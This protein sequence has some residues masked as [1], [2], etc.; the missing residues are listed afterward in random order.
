MSLRKQRKTHK[1]KRRALAK[2]K[3][4]GTRKHKKKQSRAKTIVLPMTTPKNQRKIGNLIKRQFSRH[5]AKGPYSPSV[6]RELI[7]MMT[8]T[9]K[10]IRGHC[11]DPYHVQVEISPSKG[12]SKKT[13]P[14]HELEKGKIDELGASRFICRPYAD[15]L[16]QDVLLHNLATVHHIDCSKI[17]A[18]KQISANCWFNTMFMCLFISDKG[19]QFFRY[20][21]QLMIIGH[22]RDGDAWISIP[23]KLHDA[24]F[25]F[26]QAIHYSLLGNVGFMQDYDTNNIIRAVHT[27]LPHGH[28]VAKT[29]EASNPLS[30][31][32]TLM[33]YLNDD[34]IRILS[35]FVASYH[36][37]TIKGR[38]LEVFPGGSK[39]P[40][41]IALS[42]D[43]N[44]STHYSGNQKTP[45]LKI[46]F[47]RFGKK[48]TYRLDS[49]II[50]NTE[51]HHFCATLTCNGREYGFD[52][53]SLR[54]MVPF[55]WKSK[56]NKDEDWTFDG[57]LDGDV[58]LLW[59]F[60]KGYQILFYYRV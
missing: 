14:A 45:E 56:I 53:M 37:P 20:F 3:R 19:R 43:D 6:N 49:A 39:V 40:D 24:L 23:R 42:M 41:I 52:G 31:Y 58:Q 28:T 10:T 57:S 4:R 50:R 34:T 46:K 27:A 16:A 55:N 2:H 8:K 21:R 48:I 26:N 11:D 1:H 17:V 22:R 9:P 5:K 7:Q 13:P 32:E 25:L 51:K 18:P 15:K 60:R 47:T 29:S 59:N 33:G 44:V 30:F 35:V 12:H 36:H 38:I 54:R